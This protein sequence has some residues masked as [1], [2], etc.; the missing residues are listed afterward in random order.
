MEVKSSL[1]F[2]QATGAPRLDSTGG[3]R[4]ESR[5]EEPIEGNVLPDL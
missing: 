3:G 1:L 2:F 4:D 5:Q